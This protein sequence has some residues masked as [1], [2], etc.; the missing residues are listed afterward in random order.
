MEIERPQPAAFNYTAS[1]EIYKEYSKIADH[2][3][4]LSVVAIA[5]FSFLSLAAFAI[6]VIKVTKL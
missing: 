2:L 5:L 3:F 6:L 4:V 1:L